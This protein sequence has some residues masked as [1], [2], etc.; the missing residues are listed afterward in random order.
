MRWK[1]GGEEGEKQKKSKHAQVPDKFI[2]SKEQQQLQRR[3]AWD[4]FP[5]L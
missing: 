1:G 2:V 5:L 4:G 3:H